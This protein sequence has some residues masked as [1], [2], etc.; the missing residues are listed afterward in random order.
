MTVTVQ[1]IVLLYKYTVR[2]DRNIQGVQF[3]CNVILFSLSNKE[4][5]THFVKQ[6][7]KT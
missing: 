6:I 7:R 5:F 2:M 3:Q 1:F 4:P